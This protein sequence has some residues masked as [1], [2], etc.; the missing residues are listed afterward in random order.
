MGQVSPLA[1]LLALL[2]YALNSD[3]YQSID[4]M[5]S[6]I[7]LSDKPS[8]R[9]LA[10]SLQPNVQHAIG[11]LAKEEGAPKSEVAHLLIERALQAMGALPASIDNPD[12]DAWF[13]KIKPKIRRAFA[14]SPSPLPDD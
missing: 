2:A 7:G 14:L 10:L 9:R 11:K 4:P 1:T 12:P 3:S 13:Q 8:S 5:K 6:L